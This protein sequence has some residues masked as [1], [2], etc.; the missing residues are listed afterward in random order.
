MFAIDGQKTSPVLLC[1][2]NQDFAR[3]HQ[4]FFIRQRDFLPRPER[5]QG[6]H[7]TRAADNGGQDQVDLVCSGDRRCSRQTRQNFDAVLA[8]NFSQKGNIFFVLDCHTFG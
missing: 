2:I 8:H 3:H 1:G 4:R 5:H 7:Q 6:R